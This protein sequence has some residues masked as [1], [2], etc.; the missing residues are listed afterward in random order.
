MSISPTGSNMVTA[1]T[2]PTTTTSNS[3]NDKNSVSTQSVFGA[4]SNSSGGGSVGKSAA[5]KSASKSSLCPNGNP[6]CTGCGACKSS[7]KSSETG[8]DGISGQISKTNTKNAIKAYEAQGIFSAN[9]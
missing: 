4:K 5:T 6:M 8:A 7:L 2:S 9:A 1:F 3:K